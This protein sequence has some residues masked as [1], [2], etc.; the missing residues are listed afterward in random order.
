MTPLACD[1]QYVAAVTD[2]SIGRSRHLN[3]PLCCMCVEVWIG[4]QEDELM[5]S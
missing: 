1:K 4:T 2:G 3:K 5:I